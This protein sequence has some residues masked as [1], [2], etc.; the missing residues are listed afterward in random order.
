MAARV[1]IKSAS[2]IVKDVRAKLLDD[3]SV[4]VFVDLFNLFAS[5]S[6]SLYLSSK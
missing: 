3:F 5:N 2:I 1:K 4:R 6:I